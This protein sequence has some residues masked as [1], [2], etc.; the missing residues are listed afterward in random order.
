M[1]LCPV[2]I[3]THLL[4]FIWKCLF[5]NKS[6]SWCI[7]GLAVPGTV[8]PGVAVFLH[9]RSPPALEAGLVQ[10]AGVG[11]TAPQAWPWL[12]LIATHGLLSRRHPRLCSWLRVQSW[13]AVSRPLARAV[14]GQLLG[15]QSW[16]DLSSSTYQVTP[17]LSP[18]RGQAKL[19]RRD[20]SIFSKSSSS[21]NYID[22]RKEKLQTSY[23]LNALHSTAGVA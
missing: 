4:F 18:R 2:P 8:G 16:A 7:C 10:V 20:V 6:S 15:L 17:P 11:W 9:V 14:P 13:R 21:L 19:N 1:P 12:L 23:H 3:K 22:L 5:G